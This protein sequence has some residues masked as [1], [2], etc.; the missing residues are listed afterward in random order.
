MELTPHRLMGIILVLAL[1]SAH[2]AEPMR[3]IYNAPE[4]SLDK[5]YE[6][7]WEI[8]KTSLE[9]TNQQYGPYEMQPSVRMTEQRQAF[10]LR[11]ATGKLTVMYL[12]TTPEFERDLVP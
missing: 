12:S 10:E 2:G 6:Y 5:R 7:H 8:L 9:K 1:Q 4:S 3:Y 11:N